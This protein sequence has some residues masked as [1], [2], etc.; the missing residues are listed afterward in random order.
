MSDAL[1]GNW[2]RLISGAADSA[3]L[4]YPISVDQRH[5]FGDRALTLSR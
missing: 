4:A 5:A 1:S 2:Y 3:V